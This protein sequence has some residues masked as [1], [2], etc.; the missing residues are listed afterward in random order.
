MRHNPSAFVNPRPFLLLLAG[1]AAFFLAS[2]GS[3][4]AQ[5]KSDSPVFKKYRPPPQPPL[6]VQSDALYQMWETFIV[7]RKANAG[8]VLA[9]HELSLRYLLGRGAAADTVRAAYW[10]RRASDQ[11]YTPAMFNYGIMCYNGWGVPWD[12]FEAY[13]MFRACAGRGMVESEYAMAQFLTEDLVIPR[14]FDS[15]Y[16]WVKRSADGGYAPAK[17]TLARLEKQ[18]LGPGKQESERAAAAPKAPN[19]GLV[20]LDFAQ[21]TGG[22][23]GDSLLL[24]EAIQTASPSV[25][26]ALGI[27]K[28]LETETQA[29]TATLAAIMQAGEAGSPEAL[30]VLGRSYEKGI[31]VPKDPVRAA[32]AYVRAIR[33]DSPRAPELLMKLLEQKTTLPHIKA[34]AAKGEPEAEFAWAGVSALGF[35][36][37]LAQA[38]VYLSGDEA[39]KLLSSAGEKG[40]TPALVEEGLAYYAGRWVPQSLEKATE[41]WTRA[42][43]LGS[44]DAIV[45]IALMTLRAQGDTSGRKEAVQ[46]LRRASDEGSVLAEVGLGYCYE[47]GTGLPVRDAEAAFYYRAASVRGSQDSFRALRRMHDAIRPDDPEF[48]IPD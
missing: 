3:A 47:T 29:D 23:S 22:V 34:A 6:V 31:G 19:T 27:S 46:I 26:K 35:D 20:F 1:C 10:M 40:Y 37:V 30:T 8:D 12:P 38:Q 43:S 17:E 16:A 32:A 18:G 48:R 14:N 4:G 41:L 2:P 15:A 11:N 7:T 36:G 5:E 21:D 44:K 24:K 39:F 9:Q 13:R 28:M 25:R 42:A 45:R 33:L